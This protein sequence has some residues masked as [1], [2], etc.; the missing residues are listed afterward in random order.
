MTAVE[1][2]ERGLTVIEDL[3]AVIIVRRLDQGIL[4]VRRNGQDKLKR[5]DQL[6]FGKT[7][8]PFVRLFVEIHQTDAVGFELG[9]DIDHRLAVDVVLAVAVG[10]LG[11][12]GGDFHE[13]FP[14]PLVVADFFIDRFSRI[15]VLFEQRLVEHI[16]K[17]DAG[18]VVLAGHFAAPDIAVADSGELCVNLVELIFVVDVH[19]GFEHF[20]RVERTNRV[21]D[22]RR[23]PSVLLAANEVGELDLGHG[24]GQQRRFRRIDGNRAER[25]VEL[26][27]ELSVDVHQFLFQRICGIVHISVAGIRQNEFV[28]VI[29][30][31]RRRSGVTRSGSGI[32]RL[33][34]RRG[35]ARSRSGRGGILGIAA[36]SE[37]RCDHD[38]CEEQ[39]KDALSVHAFSSLKWVAF[40]HT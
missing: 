31:L 6:R 39:R 19:A 35:N 29:A 27:F 38:D 16:G 1:T 11:D 21:V 23:N 24:V 15:T 28:S 37:Q 34:R 3:T 8:G 9:F 4:R 22:R 40:Q 32:G 17:A 30:C 36:R 10:I 5:L 18:D 7:G 26:V 2:A 13:V 20:G 33:I 25:H 14:C 12:L